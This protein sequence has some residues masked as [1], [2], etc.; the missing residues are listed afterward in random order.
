MSE[1]DA[2]ISPD[3]AYRAGDRCGHCREGGATQCC[4]R[5]RAVCYCNATCQRAAWKVHKPMCKRA[6][7]ARAS[8]KVVIKGGLAALTAL[9]QGGDV[10]AAYNVGVRHEFGRQG[11]PRRDA[12]EAAKWYKVAAEAGGQNSELAQFNLARLLE[13]GCE[14]VRQDS[15]EAGRWYAAAVAQGSAAACFALGHMFRKNAT[16]LNDDAMMAKSHLLMMGA[17]EAGDPQ[18]MVQCSANLFIGRGCE[19]DQDM[20]ID[21]LVT[22]A[23]EGASYTG[24]GGD[25][26]K[27]AQVA[28]QALAMAGFDAY[29]EPLEGLSDSGE[30]AEAAAEAGA[31]ATNTSKKLPWTNEEVAGAVA[32]A[33]AEVEAEAVAK[34]EAVAEAKAAVGAAGGGGGGKKKRKGKKGKNRRG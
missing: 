17:V 26:V 15:A 22:A 27:Q 11:A 1:T 8:N 20:A 2:A 6:K 14:G 10:N 30:E 18:A 19:A 12:K 13:T 34:A 29:G 24:G 33:M 23:Q 32:G 3:S 5:C 7:E 25:P 28:R 21:L 4:S 9:A 16:R 31:E